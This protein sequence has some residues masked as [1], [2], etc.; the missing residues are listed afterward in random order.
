MISLWSSGSHLMFS[1]TCKNVKQLYYNYDL[2]RACVKIGLLLNE[3]IIP[4]GFKCG[5]NTWEECHI[6]FMLC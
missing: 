6:A 5:N 3:C 2:F 1:C 4:S